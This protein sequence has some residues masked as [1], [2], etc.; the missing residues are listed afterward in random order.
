[1]GGEEFAG[2][3]PRPRPAGED[4]RGNSAAK[5][6]TPVITDPVV[7]AMVERIA[8]LDRAW[9]KRH[10]DRAHRVRR[11]MPN[12]FPGTVPDGPLAWPV[13]VIVKQITPG[14][15]MRSAFRGTRT[16]CGCE[17]CTADL[18]ERFASEQT[19]RIA[20]DIAT[21]MLRHGR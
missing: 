19:K 8:D 15:R 2:G 17:S 1:M 21:I 7:A 6:E 14:T 5:P 4:A 11:M 16:P 13:F 20:H 18:W 9:F 12:E 3:V 10:P